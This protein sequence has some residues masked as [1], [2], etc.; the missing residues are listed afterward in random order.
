MIGSRSTN[1]C[2]QARSGSLSSDLDV[3]RAI[4]G[5]QNFHTGNPSGRELVVGERN[6]VL[7]KGERVITAAANE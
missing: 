1:Q 6:A 3:V 5:L 4:L 2:P 7:A